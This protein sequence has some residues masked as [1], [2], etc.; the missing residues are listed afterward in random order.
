M[1]DQ[2]A[3][4]INFR[5]GMVFICAQCAGG[6]KMIIKMASY[7]VQET[8]YRLEYDKSND[9]ATLYYDN[10][11]VWE[12]TGYSD[13]PLIQQITDFRDLFQSALDGLE[14]PL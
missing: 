12:L 2:G 9:A 11:E 7:I 14:K 4:S 10:N 3:G 8:N 13:Y 6:L 1:D 5:P